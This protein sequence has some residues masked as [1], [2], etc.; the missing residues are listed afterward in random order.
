MKS[1]LSIRSSIRIGRFD[2]LRPRRPGSAPGSCGPGQPNAAQSLKPPPQLRPRPQA[3]YAAFLQNA[4]R[5]PTHTRGCTPGW[6]AVPRWGTRIIDGLISGGWGTPM[7]HRRPYPGLVGHANESSTA[8][9]RL[10]KATTQ[11]RRRLS[12][13]D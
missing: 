13:D 6:Y 2:S 8:L 5:S 7:N 3:T 12:S 1:K 9:S 10:G 11:E 4:I